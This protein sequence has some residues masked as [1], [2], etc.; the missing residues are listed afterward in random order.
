MLVVL[1]EHLL[2]VL[3]KV[4]LKDSAPVLVQHRVVHRRRPVDVRQRPQEG[5]VGAVVDGSEGGL[6]PAVDVARGEEHLRV[7]VR[8]DE[9]LREGGGRPVADGLAVSEERVPLVLAE[10]ADAVE[11]GGEGLA[12][13]ETVGRVFGAGVEHVVGV[14]VA[15]L[16]E[17][18]AEGWVWGS[19][20]V[21]GGLE[22]AGCV[23]AVPVRPRPRQRT[24]MGTTR[25]S[26]RR[27]MSVS[28]VKTSVIGLE[29]PPA[30]KPMMMACISRFFVGGVSSVCS[31]R[32]RSSRRVNE[33]TATLKW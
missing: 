23:H 29:A 27:S 8:G 33:A 32:A 2:A 25:V 28:F 20:R 18:C 1:E 24:F 15:Q 10:G 3:L 6:V 5:V 30:V 26:L 19:G 22:G 31:I 7:R 13:E 17:G 16:F 9:L 11:L 14:D 4:A 12:P 21:V